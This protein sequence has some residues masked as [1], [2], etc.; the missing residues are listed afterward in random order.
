M[1][2]LVSDIDGT[3]TY[4]NGVNYPSVAPV[5]KIAVGKWMEAGNVFAVATARVHTTADWFMND[6]GMRVDYLGGNGAESVYADG[7]CQI[8]MIPSYVFLK[9]AK[10]L[11]EQN[12][13]ATIKMNY[14]HYFYYYKN[15]NY[16][17]T[18]ES[19]MRK[20]LRT[21]EDYQL[22]N[23]TGEEGVCNMSVLTEER[24]QDVKDY[25][26]TTFADVCSAVCSDYDNVDFI[27]KGSS[28]SI[29]IQELAKRYHLSSDDVYVIGDSENDIS[30]FSVTGHSYAM[31]QASDEV[32]RQAAH[33]VNTVSEA[34]LGI[35]E[36]DTI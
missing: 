2:L 7:T 6:L 27:P 21:A 3:L 4:E 14:E 10:W 33:V 9:T 34:I 32:K 23:L 11:D 36:E 35:L 29:A 19:R 18:C 16:P 24:I 30:M 25:I 13:N 28:K 26:N 8:R 15:T 22:L 17:F 5:N 12:I 31:A 1:K 20:T